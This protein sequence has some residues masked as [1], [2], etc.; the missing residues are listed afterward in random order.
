[1]TRWA[2]IL[3]QQATWFEADCTK[4]SQSQ[5]LGIFDR[6]FAI[7]RFRRRKNDFLGVPSQKKTSL[8]FFDHN[9][10]SQSIVPSFDI[11]FQKKKKTL[12][13]VP[14]AMEIAIAIATPS[15]RLRYPQVWGKAGVGKTGA[16]YVWQLCDADVTY[17]RFLPLVAPC[18]WDFNRGRGRG[19]ESRPLSRFCFAL[20]SKGSRHY[21]TTMARLSPLSGLERGGWGLPPVFGCEKGEIGASQSHSLSQRGSAVEGVKQRQYSIQPVEGATN[22]WQ[23]ATEARQKTDSKLYFKVEEKVCGWNKSVENKGRKYIFTILNLSRPPT[24]ARAGLGLQDEKMV[25]VVS[26]ACCSDQRLFTLFW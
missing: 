4:R 8:A 3:T 23:P 9:R 6:K 12:V 26:E 24:K 2:L 17:P 10:Q 21:S 19:W 1:M 15:L 13:I 14:I 22:N 18:G 5:S 25:E 7:A 20:V 16:S 11:G